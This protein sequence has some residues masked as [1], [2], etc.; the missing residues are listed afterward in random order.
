M[1]SSEKSQIPKPKLQANHK[2][3]ISIRRN[4]HESFTRLVIEIWN[5]FGAWDLGF[6]ACCSVASLRAVTA[7]VKNAAWSAKF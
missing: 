3:Q 2:S 1:P 6:S 4:S 7:S 5:L